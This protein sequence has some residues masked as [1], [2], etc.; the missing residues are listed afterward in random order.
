MNN[1]I[2]MSVSINFLFKV[3]GIKETNGNYNNSI[4]LIIMTFLLTQDVFFY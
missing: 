2:N 1:R 3:T 4:N